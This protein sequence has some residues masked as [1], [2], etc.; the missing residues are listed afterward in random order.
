MFYV[1]VIDENGFFLEDAFVSEITPLTIET[2]CPDGFY[3]PRWDGEKWVEGGA[4][5]TPEPP[6]PTQ[7]ERLAAL[8]AAMLEVLTGGLV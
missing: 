5:P 1:R 2:L 7:E 4:P 6:I 8:E 3:R